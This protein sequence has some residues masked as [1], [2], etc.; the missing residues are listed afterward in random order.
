MTEPKKPADH[1]PKAAKPK[2]EK[3]KVTRE[4]DGF[5]VEHRGIKVTIEIAALDD[6]ELLRDLGR[7]QDASVPEASKFAGIPGVFTRLFG[8]QQSGR[9]L[10]GLRDP[11]TKRVTV[12]AASSFL[13]E[14]FGALNPES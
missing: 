7:M 6:F 4:E 2:K 13:F 12:S 11:K 3:P 14:V 9:V 8:E 10:D 1:K 5:I